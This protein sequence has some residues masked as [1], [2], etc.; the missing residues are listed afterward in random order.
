MKQLHFI[1]LLLSLLLSS[2]SSL[3]QTP[4]PASADQA[5]ASANVTN[6]SVYTKVEKMA[7]FPGGINGMFNFLSRNIKYPESAQQKD[8]Q[9]CVVIK[10]IIDTDGKV[11]DPKV[12]ESVDP[13]LDAEALRIVSIMPVWQPGIND[14]VP[15]KSYYTMPVHFRLQKIDFDKKKK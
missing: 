3:G 2:L 9:G 11:I 12:I 8:I 10:F 15:V 7:E 1:P 4:A 5:S 13:A 6:D 14:G